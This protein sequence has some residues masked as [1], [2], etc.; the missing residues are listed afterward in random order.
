[1]CCRLS[2]SGVNRITPRVATRRS[3][4]KHRRSRPSTPLMADW[5]R[6][7]RRPALVTFRSESSASSATSR[8]RSS[9][10]KSTR[11]PLYPLLQLAAREVHLGAA[12]HHVQKLLVFT[13]SDD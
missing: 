12:L 7:T 1:G 9:P 2:A 10:W 5:L 8:F 13:P 11:L 6:W 4:W 3:S